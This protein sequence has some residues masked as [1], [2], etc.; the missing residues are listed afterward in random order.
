[1]KK[2]V[3]LL[4]L[5]AL[6][7]CGEEPAPEPTAT[8]AAAEPVEPTAPPADEALFTELFAETCP[9]AEPV[10]TAVCKRAMGADTATCQ[11]GLG[12]DQNLRHSAQIAAENGE[13]SLVDAPAIC[14]EHD[15]H[16]VD[17]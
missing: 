15:S 13:W 3:F 6:S 11:F 8:V 14:A 2:T 5:F 7:A 16:H 9:D 10:A 4:P 1:M 12:E 17:T